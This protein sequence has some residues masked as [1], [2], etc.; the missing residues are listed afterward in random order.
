MKQELK[1]LLFTYT[2][3]RAKK[4][5]GEQQGNTREESCIKHEI[6]QKKKS[7]GWKRNEDKVKNNDRTEK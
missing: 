6:G 5:K 7:T 4:A 1:N 2:E 3:G